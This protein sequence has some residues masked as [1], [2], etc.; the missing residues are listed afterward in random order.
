MAIR[1]AS[2]PPEIVVPADQPL[3]EMMDEIDGQDVI[4]YFFS[5]ED[6]DAARGPDTARAAREL[7][8]AWSD[9]DWE[10][11][12]EELDRIRHGSLPTPP[13]QPA[14]IAAA[15]TNENALRFNMSAAMARVRG[16]SRPGSRPS[17]CS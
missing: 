9:L 7:A 15:I 17:G 13:M 3:I 2:R 11:T 6:A 4:R 1:Q 12:V 5:E 16:P 8:G 14:L 10:E